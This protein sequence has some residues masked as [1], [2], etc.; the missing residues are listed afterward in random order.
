MAKPVDNVDLWAKDAVYTNGPYAGLANKQAIPAAVASEGFIPGAANPSAAEHVNDYLQKLSAL[1]RWVFDGS[2]AGG[3]D[4]HIVE[5]DG[6]GQAQLAQLYVSPVDV[7][8]YGARFDGGPAGSAYA[9]QVINTTAD[10]GVLIQSSLGTGLVVEAPGGNGG[11]FTAEDGWSLI[12]DAPDGDKAPL[13]LG[14]RAGDYANAT[15]G[16]FGLKTDDGGT[17]DH[18]RVH[19]GEWRSPWHT[20]HGYCGLVATAGTVETN[21]NTTAMAAKNFGAYN[22]PKQVGKV[23]VC[24]VG[25]VGRTGTCQIDVGIYDVTS[26]VYVDQRTFNLY[27]SGAG[28]YERTETVRAVYTLPASGDRSFRVDIERNGG[29]G[30]DLARVRNQTLSVRGVFD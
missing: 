29:G 27:Q 23:E 12:V 26:G 21:T 10:D 19:M 25:E 8:T 11:R 20:R 14:G 17:G 15:D 16:Q 30:A 22:A 7:N 3:A 5:T 18:V 6:D 13:V 4:A 28:V 24:W 2:F 1:A 9:V